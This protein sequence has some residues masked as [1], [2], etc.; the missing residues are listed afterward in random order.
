MNIGNV[1]CHCILLVVTVRKDHSG[2]NCWT[3]YQPSA[4]NL[5]GISCSQTCGDLIFVNLSMQVVEAR[6]VNSSVIVR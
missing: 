5:Q 6:A 2:A 4:N 3:L 1:K